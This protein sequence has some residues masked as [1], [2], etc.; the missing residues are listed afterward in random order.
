MRGRLISGLLALALASGGHLVYGANAQPN[1]TDQSMPANALPEALVP[2]DPLPE[3][4]VGPLTLERSSA[5]DALRLVLAQSGTGIGLTYAGSALPRPLRRPVAAANLEGDLPELVEQ[6]AQVAGFEYEY[7]A[8]ARVLT[9]S[10][11]REYRLQLPADP[12]RAAALAARIH[13]LG[14]VRL[15]E[16]AAA[17]RLVYAANPASEE[18]ILRYLEASRPQGA[19]RPNPGNRESG[20]PNVPASRDPSGD[21]RAALAHP[22]P[23][24]LWEV[25]P[26]ELVSHALERWSKR[27]GWQLVWQAPELEAGIGASVGGSFEQAVMQVLR[28]LDENGARLRPIFYA[29]NR[30]L[31]ITGAD[32]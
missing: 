28:S 15:E 12:G 14:G 7:D 29:G 19:N 3:A 20:A 5:F 16:G 31:R 24:P 21:T 17:R 9:V 1:E 25:N 8:R 26:S 11:E 2:S 30:V 32:R 10:A 4:P 13:A 6:L 27:A 23:E 18:Q 22:A